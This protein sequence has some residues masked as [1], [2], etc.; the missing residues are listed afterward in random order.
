MTDDARTAAMSQMLYHAN[1][2]SVGVTYL[3]WFFLGMFGAHRFYAGRKG[4]GVAQLL[5]T[6]VGIITAAAVVGFLFLGLNAIWVIID[7]FLIPGM[8]RSSNTE[9]AGRLIPA[10]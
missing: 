10:G 3:L 6:M 2:K 4:S 1:S 9:L 5:I 8:V 7:A